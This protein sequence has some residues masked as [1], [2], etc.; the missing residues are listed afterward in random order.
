MEFTTMVADATDE[1]FEKWFECDI[2]ETYLI[3]ALAGLE[4]RH[5]NLFTPGTTESYY[6]DRYERDARYIARIVRIKQRL[7]NT[8]VST[9]QVNLEVTPP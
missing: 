2:E 3:I 7:A 5:H 4:L 1:E 6:R 8:W 9:N